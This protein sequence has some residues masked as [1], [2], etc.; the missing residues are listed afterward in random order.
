MIARYT[1]NPKYYINKISTIERTHKIIN[2]NTRI[3]FLVMPQ[4]QTF[5]KYYFQLDETIIHETLFIIFYV[6]YYEQFGYF[7]YYA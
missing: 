7:E 5:Q 3:L 2:I 6:E 1:Q 4:I